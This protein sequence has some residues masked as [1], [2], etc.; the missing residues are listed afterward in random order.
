M[1]INFDLALGSRFLPR[2]TPPRLEHVDIRLFTPAGPGAVD[3]FCRQVASTRLQSFTLASANMS[4]D[5]LMH[6]FQ[7]CP[8]LVRFGLSECNIGRGEL[9]GTLAECLANTPLTLDQMKMSSVVL[10]HHIKDAGY[11]QGAGGRHFLTPWLEDDDRRPGH[12]KRALR[13]LKLK[14]AVEY[15]RYCI[16]VDTLVKLLTKQCATVASIDI[17]SIMS[18]A[19]LIDALCKS[20]VCPRLQELTCRDR[21][22][23]AVPSNQPIQ[24][25]DWLAKHP[26]IATRRCGSFFEFVVDRSN[27][28][29]LLSKMLELAE[30]E[31]E[32]ST[33]HLKLAKYKEASMDRMLRSMFGWLGREELGFLHTLQLTGHEHSVLNFSVLSELSAM[34]L[35]SLSL[36]DVGVIDVDDSELSDLLDL[37]PCLEQLTIQVGA[38]TDD[39]GIEV[40]R[41][42]HLDLSFAS[43]LRIADHPCLQSAEITGRPWK[44]LIDYAA[45]QKALWTAWWPEWWH[46]NDSWTERHKEFKAQLPVRC[47]VRVETQ[48][49]FEDGSEDDADY[50][51]CE[52]DASVET[53]LH[54]AGSF[55]LTF[56]VPFKCRH[57]CAQR[58]ECAGLTCTF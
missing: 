17:H 21:K 52:Q 3:A 26:R 28:T 51:S 43:V 49:G 36:I 8:R 39:D 15:S 12:A 54:V 6:L 30:H 47:K 7:T 38:F 11:V 50:S 23:I 42:Q 20:P 55:Q 29:Q 58:S 46:E 48:G 18:D 19:V 9:V 44:G 40:K 56:V 24:V 33:L 5:S 13:I 25:L 31:V 1:A 32:L 34:S 16:D 41:P 10:S 14:T 27:L 57:R 37:L 53:F 45:D 22:V 2:V 4:L 35:R